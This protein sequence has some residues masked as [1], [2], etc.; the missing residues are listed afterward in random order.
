[1]DFERANK[2]KGHLAMLLLLVSAIMTVAALARVVGLFTVAADAQTLLAAAAKY[3][4]DPNNID[5][6]LAEANKMAEDLKKKNLFVPPIT[7]Q[8]PVKAV[9]GI[10]GDEALINGNWYKAKAK[11]GDAEILA[12]EP[13]RVNI[14]W[15]GQEKWFAPIGSS[16]PQPP[17]P[18]A[19]PPVAKQPPAEVV[20]KPATQPQQVEAKAPEPPKVEDPFAW[21]GVN[22]SDSLKA[23]LLDQWNRLDDT[24]KQRMKE[25][26][27]AMSDEQ[28]QQ[29]VSMMEQHL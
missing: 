7:K 2:T 18:P 13:T 20:P 6:Y 27:L 9:T 29:A 4:A 10:F 23:K 12:I 1:M 28:K 24:Q 15:E 3:G 8:H 5:G 11:V 16:S 14:K 22:L 21:L 17:E 25:Q 19:K 26:W